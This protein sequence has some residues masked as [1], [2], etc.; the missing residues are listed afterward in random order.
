MRIIQGQTIYRKLGDGST[1]KE[2]ATAFAKTDQNA[3]AVHQ[4]IISKCG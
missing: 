1:R 3:A 4:L 2:Q